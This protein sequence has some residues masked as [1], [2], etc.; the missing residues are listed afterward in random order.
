M[1]L[2]V[3]KSLN[4]LDPEY[5]SDMFKIYIVNPVGHVEGGGA[6]VVIEISFYPDVLHLLVKCFKLRLFLGNI[7]D[8]TH[9]TFPCLRL[10]LMLGF[11]HI[12]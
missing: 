7:A 11:N 8:C 9:A 5:I 3:F 6:L 10:I 2:L 1:L 12:K 4:G